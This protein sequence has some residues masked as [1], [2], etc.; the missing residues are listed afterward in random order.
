MEQSQQDYENKRNRNLKILHSRNALHLKAVAA[1]S[2]MQ[3]EYIYIKHFVREL[4]RRNTVYKNGKPLTQI[5]RV[6]LPLSFKYG[7]Y[8]DPYMIAGCGIYV[9]DVIKMSLNPHDF[10]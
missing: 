10:A 5:S 1:K 2:R 6:H 9:E 8:N 3:G 7:S 4:D